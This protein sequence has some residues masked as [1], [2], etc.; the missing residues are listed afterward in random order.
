MAESPSVRRPLLKGT[1]EYKT[2]QCSDTATQVGLRHTAESL[3]IVLIEVFFDT[4]NKSMN[5]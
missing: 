3:D 2:T 1:P 4:T 5:E